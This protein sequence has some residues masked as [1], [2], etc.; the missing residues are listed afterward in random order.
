MSNALLTKSWAVPLPPA[1]KICL[2]YLADRAN[3]Q[4]GRA[5]WPSIATIAKATGCSDRTVQRSLQALVDKGHISRVGQ[6]GRSWRF[7][8]HPRHGVTPTPDTVSPPIGDA[9]PVT[10]SPTP[11][12]MSGEGCHGVTQTQTEPKEEPKEEPKSHSVCASTGVE[13]TPGH[14]FE[15]WD[16]T[17]SS[18]GRNPIRRRT[19]ARIAKVEAI[20]SEYSRNDIRQALSNIETSSWLCKSNVLTFDWATTPENFLKILEGNYDDRTRD[21][22]DTRDG[23]T[24][25]ID[26]CWADDSGGYDSSPW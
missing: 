23:F 13:V 8:V 9:T 20:L 18:I 15:A 16:K 26:R 7:T 5:A 12:T 17:M 6:P 22:R 1:E 21:T 25:A 4:K 10:V 3:D 2:I 24:K 19:A 11:D 14:F